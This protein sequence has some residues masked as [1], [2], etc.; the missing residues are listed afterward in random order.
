MFSKSQKRKTMIISAVTDDMVI[1]RMNLQYLAN[2]LAILNK[3]NRESR[4]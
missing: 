1:N 2:K 4:L 3:T